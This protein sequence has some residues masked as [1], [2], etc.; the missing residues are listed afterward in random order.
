[1]RWQWSD[2]TGAALLWVLVV[3][4]VGLLIVAGISAL[5]PVNLRKAKFEGDYALAMYTAESGVN[6]AI[7]LLASFGHAEVNEAQV[8]EINALLATDGGI[9]LSAGGQYSTELAK[10]GPYKFEVL[11]TGRFEGRERSVLVHIDDVGGSVFRSYVAD[12]NDP[13]FLRVPIPVPPATMVDGYPGSPR[14]CSDLENGIIG[15]PNHIYVRITEP[16]TNLSGLKIKNATVFAEHIQIS[17]GNPAVASFEDAELY[18]AEHFLYSGSNFK[19]SFAGGDVRENNLY[20]QGDVSVFGSNM[21]VERADAG[22]A[23]DPLPWDYIQTGGRIYIGGANHNNVGV[24]PHLVL[25]ANCE[26]SSGFTHTN[27]Q[28][29]WLDENEACVYTPGSALNFVG[30]IY[31]PNGKVLIDGDP[32]DWAAIGSIV[33]KKLEFRTDDPHGDFCGPKR[34]PR[35]CKLR[36]ELEDSWRTIEGLPERMATVKFGQDRRWQSSHWEL[37]DGEVN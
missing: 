32:T 25:A 35:P 24:D 33:G 12:E 36:D 30:G 34:D 31:A 18:V 5:S 1:M 2:Q 6:H 26:V 15:Y 27:P 37:Y 17:G 20:V 9:D 28:A 11:S 4:S 19:V 10:I 23:P 29:G 21:N 22:N 14:S 13:D 8:S 16:C 3:M 7:G